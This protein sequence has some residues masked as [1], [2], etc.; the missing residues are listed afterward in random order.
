MKCASIRN[1]IMLTS[2]MDMNGWKI[3][4]MPEALDGEHIKSSPSMVTNST[5]MKSFQYAFGIVRLYIGKKERTQMRKNHEQ[6]RI[7]RDRG[8][9]IERER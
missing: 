9:K 7:E 2:P 1:E 3:E 5:R 8:R 4:K 6:K